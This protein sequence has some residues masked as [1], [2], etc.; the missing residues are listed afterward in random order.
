MRPYVVLLAGTALLLFVV[1]TVGWEVDYWAS[2]VLLSSG[3]LLA[4][5]V[6]L[7]D[8]PPEFV[9][10]WRRGALGERRT[11]KALRQLEKRGWKI[12]HDRE[13]DGLGNVDHLALSPSGTAYVIE[14]K[15][16]GGTV[17]VERGILTQRFG[18]ERAPFKHDALAGQVR[19]RAERVRRAW[20]RRTRKP[21]PPIRPVVAIWGTFS[22]S[23]ECDGVVYVSGTEL[24]ETLA[25]MD[26]DSATRPA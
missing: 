17:S 21:P 16:L 5:A 2:V 7:R 11:G 18:D 9:D 8:D 4:M 10:R 26:G 1:A 13:L 19:A 25:R 14:T 24:P 15:A 23:V 3:G 12:R 6:W 20:S 22:G